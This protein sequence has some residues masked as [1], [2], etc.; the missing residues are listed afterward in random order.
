ME[1]RIF[2]E[3]YCPKTKTVIKYYMHEDRTYDM[4]FEKVENY[5][6]VVST[7]EVKK[8]SSLID[9]SK[10]PK[11]EKVKVY[12]SEDKLICET[13]N[14]LVF[15]Y[16]RAE[17]AKHGY[18]GCY[19]IFRGERLS[20]NPTGQLEDW[21]NGLFDEELDMLDIILKTTFKS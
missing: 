7:F 9:L 3:D 13:D 20:I 17:I 14:S 18:E 11:N 10:C 1:R 21:P 16:V 4:E 12:D 19:V 6:P 15:T 2:R 5:E 8:K